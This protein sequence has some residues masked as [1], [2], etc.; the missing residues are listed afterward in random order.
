MDKI[1][2]KI[3]GMH[4]ASCAIKIEAQL[5]KVSGVT[6]A[7]VNYTLAE[8]SVHFDPAQTSEHALHDVVIQQGY[9]VPSMEMPM[10]QEH[11]GHAEPEHNGNHMAHGDEQGALRRAVI[12][13]VIAIPVLII[14]MARLRFGPVVFGEM[15]SDWIEAVGGSFVVLGPG[16]VFHKTT[17]Q[18]IKHWNV[19]MDT[20]ITMGT[21]AA[22]AFSWWA[23]AVDEPRYFETAG[24]ITAFILLGRYLEARSKGQASTAIQKLLE[25]GAKMAHRLKADGTSEDV[26]VEQLKKGDIV[27]VKPG[28]K[29]PL[30]GTVKEG[31]SSVDESMLTGESLPIGKVVGDSVFGATMN[32]QGALTVVITI[33]SEGSVLA[34][35]IELVKE[36]QRKKAPIQ[37]LADKISGVFVP[38][39]IGVA[40]VTFL[41][42][43]VLSKDVSQA[44]IAA[45]A[46]LVI[47]CPCALG[48]ATPTAILVG[49]GRGARMGIL[50]KSGEAL[51]RGRNL[52]IIM[53]DKTGTLTQGKPV[54][55]D[56]VPASAVDARA[57][58]ELSAGAES[59]SEHPL[60]RA[61]VERA[62]GEDITP[63]KATNFLSH[64]GKGIEARVEGAVVRVGQDRWM[65]ELGIGVPDALK[66]AFVEL[67]GQGK[68]VVFVAKEHV[69]LGLLAIADQSKPHAKETV[70]RLR[71]TGMRVIMITGDQERTARAIAHELGI[72]DVRAQVFPDQ[73]LE[74][75]KEAQQ[76]GKRVAFVG[77]GINDAPALTQADLGIAVGT[78]TDIAIEA[79]QIVLVGGG[80]EKVV[81]AIQLSRR[82]YRGIK[83]NLF[84]AF[85]YNVVGIPLAAFGLLNP[86]IASAAM[87]FS[88][89]SVVLN[90][91]RL[92]RVKLGS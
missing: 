86:I 52:D 87:A 42:W 47:A 26:P 54:V 77:D 6:E 30:D 35:I 48:L 31:E 65:Q 20:L 78:G 45:V 12:S 22:L 80:P 64:T 13:L 33:E 36:A 72:D 92:K 75:V 19:G 29:I 49:T 43:F 83:Q 88:S 70:A 14:A 2:F 51:E 89:I 67:S 82:T 39:V 7:N 21:L 81:Q 15:L 62:K 10:Q 44:L 38:V 56:V 71:E 90:S 40:V 57:L 74:I 60:A 34:Q 17:W 63:Q 11:S 59:L 37:K 24:V 28:E 91:L 84:W 27:L 1:N 58:M 69:L 8:A 9:K 76:A 18:Q 50:I 79:G 73:K 85:I 32:Q 66:T 23:F 4:C 46:V 5:K 61:V 68:T 53:F 25:L 3:E 16:M 41:A 55:T